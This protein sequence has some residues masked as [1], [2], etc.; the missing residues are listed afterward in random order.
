AK[1]CP[2]GFKPT[3]ETGCTALPEMP[4][5]TEAWGQT[6]YIRRQKSYRRFALRVTNLDCLVA[7]RLMMTLFP[8]KSEERNNP[9][10]LYS[11][12]PAFPMAHP[13]Q[14]LSRSGD[15]RQKSLS[16]GLP[17]RARRFTAHMA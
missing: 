1:N 2:P 17:P 6:Q 7:P 3:E 11:V 14:G 5:N 15:R 4:P 8:V 9:V 12:A 10:G 16:D 13:P